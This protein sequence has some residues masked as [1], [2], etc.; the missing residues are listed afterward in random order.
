[1]NAV[2]L[3]IAVNPI[4][5]RVDGLPLFLAVGLGH[6]R[7]FV[8]A[9]DGH[10]VL[11]FAFALINRAA[12]GG[13]AGRFRRAGQR[14]VSFTGK[15]PGGGIQTNPTG[16]GQ[17]NLGPGVQIGKVFLR[18]RRA[19]QRFDVRRQL[20]QITGHEASGQP[21]VAQDLYQQ[22]GGVA[23]R[24]AAQGQRLFRRLYARFHADGVTD[25]LL[26]LLVDRHQEFR[27]ALGFIGDAAQVAFQLG[28]QRLAVQIGRQFDFLLF[29]IAKRN[30]FRLRLQEEI[31][32]VNHRHFNPHIHFHA[33]VVGFFREH[34]PGQVV[35][36]RI[37]LPVDKVIFRGHFQRIGQNG[38][39]AVCG[40]AQAYDLG[41]QVDASV[42]AIFGNVV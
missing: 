41:T 27:A 39:T 26:Q 33:E 42:V 35:A 19:I 13:G 37:L 11:K 29:R 4:T 5:E 15:Q 28:G 10:Q 40:R 1:M 36:V 23:T 2:G 31:E 12:D 7:H 17:V 22:P 20:N 25:V 18:P 30:M 3:Q 16:T 14:D 38:G 24:T 21:E 34:Q 9:G 32:G 6:T 8:H